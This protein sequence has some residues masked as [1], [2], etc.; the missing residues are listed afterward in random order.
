MPPL[1]EYVQKRAHGESH[2]TATQKL[3]IDLVPRG[4][5]N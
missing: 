3:I 2:L 4:R 1:R 5:P